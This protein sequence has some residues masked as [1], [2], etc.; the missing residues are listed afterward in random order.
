VTRLL[1][2]VSNDREA[3]MALAGGAD[4][5]DLKEPV[6][7]ALGAV[8]PAIQLKVVQRVAGRCPVSATIGDLPMVAETLSRAIA[9]TAN[10]GVDIV[11]VGLPQLEQ[12]RDCLQA[13]SDNA[14]RG[15]QIVAVLFAEHRP[16]LQLL[17]E[18]AQSGCLGAMLDTAD[19]SSG[20][21]CSLLDQASLS[22]FVRHARALGLLSGLAGSL[23]I[24]DIE[25]LIKLDPDY[26][27]FRGAL[28]EAGMRT[29]RLSISALAGVRETFDT[30]HSKST[31]SVA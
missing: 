22:A 18:L 5:I 11:K 25:P 7:G 20:H 13:L 17:D 24:A 6:H 3:A 28:C 27:G 12:H 19:K 4:I 30:V 8:A 31:L 29:E 10:T 1:A 21:L 9:A 23:T 14:A 2:S 16:A 15:V 26:L